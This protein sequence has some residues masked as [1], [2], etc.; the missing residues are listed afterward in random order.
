MSGEFYV[1]GIN[2]KWPK[3]AVNYCQEL[4]AKIQILKARLSFEETQKKRAI[5]ASVRLLNEL[6]ADFKNESHY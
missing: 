6:S 5:S 2:L 3:A 1:G 4:E